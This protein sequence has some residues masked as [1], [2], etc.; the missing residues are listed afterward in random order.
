VRAAETAGTWPDGVLR[1][2]DAF[3]L[4][5]L[6]LPEELGG[7]GAGCLAKV[8]TLETLAAADAGGRRRGLPRRRTGGRGG[9]DLPRRDGPVRAHRARR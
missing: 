6:D 3:P 9:G 2:L 8:V 4:G 7:A 1:A 5:G